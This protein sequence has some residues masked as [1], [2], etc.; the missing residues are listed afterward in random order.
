MDVVLLAP[1]ACTVLDTALDASGGA[2]PVLAT[3]SG[4]KLRQALARSFKSPGFSPAQP[5][6]A[7]QRPTSLTSLNGSAPMQRSFTQPQSARRF[8][9]LVPSAS[10]VSADLSRPHWAHPAT[11]PNPRSKESCSAGKATWLSDPSNLLSH[12][13]SAFLQAALD[14]VNSATGVQFAAV[15]LNDVRGSED[16]A[17]FKRFGI[18]LFNRWGVGSAEFN[19]GLLLLHFKDARRLEIVTGNGV[20][21]V[22]SDSWLL[23][24][25]ITRMVPHFKSGDHGRGLEV[26][27]RAIEDRLRAHP[28]DC[29][30]SAGSSGDSR[31]VSDDDASFG[32]GR[33]LLPV[34][35]STDGTHSGGRPAKDFDIS[36]I[37]SKFALLG[38]GFAG[39]LTDNYSEVE[40]RRLEACAAELERRP[41]F[42]TVGGNIHEWP[43]IVP[44]S[45]MNGLV[46]TLKTDPQ[47]AFNLARE[48]LLQIHTLGTKFGNRSLQLK[49]T[50]RSF[51]RFSVHLPPGSLFVCQDLQG[52]PLLLQDEVQEILAPGEERTLYLNTFCG[53]SGASVP[54]NVSMVLSPYCLLAEHRVTQ[55]AVWRWAARYQHPRSMTENQQSCSSARDI[56]EESFGMTSADVDHLTQDVVRLVADGEAQRRR[57]LIQVKQELQSKRAEVQ[58]NRERARQSSSGCSGSRGSGGGYSG[59]GGGS[60]SSGGA[61]CSW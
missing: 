40:L 53:D 38:L 43:Y 58:R 22:L 42:Q 57:D 26:G 28:H 12:E 52:Q 41:C 61:G 49:L 56:L 2:M 20:T 3:G 48:G 25:Q 9:S 36:N 27:I 14:H 37:L 8:G 32:G 4:K 7:S 35:Q 46:D 5:G 13:E 60:C 18:E 51:D 10:L 39:I 15:I 45:H 17:R 34:P 54:H 11:I 31:D 6:F 55:S 19:N 16:I 30:R 33:S 44:P 29:W 21:S 24:M 1:L 23:N 47:H 50:N 59:F